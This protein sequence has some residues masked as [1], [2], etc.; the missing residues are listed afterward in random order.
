MVEGGRIFSLYGLVRS[1]GKKKS[2]LLLNYNWVCCF[3]HA[4]V[5]ESRRAP[6]SRHVVG[7]LDRWLARA[8]RIIR[9]GAPVTT[10]RCDPVITRR[11]LCSGAK[12]L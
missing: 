7:S 5:H 1:F 2:L 11:F 6:S 8:S 12:N 9:G 10:T 3:T 4:E